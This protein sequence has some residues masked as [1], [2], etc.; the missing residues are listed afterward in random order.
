MWPGSPRGLK[1][2][3]ILLPMRE[4]AELT[5][6]GG[7]CCFQLVTCVALISKEKRLSNG[8]GG[9]LFTA[10]C[11]LKKKKALSVI[12]KREKEAMLLHSSNET[13]KAI[14]VLNVD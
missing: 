4:E 14:P 1:K 2:P 10:S 12:L 8:G 13:K 7:D 11:F 9:P 6:H 5:G 3:H